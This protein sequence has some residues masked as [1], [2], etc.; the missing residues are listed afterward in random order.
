MTSDS[1]IHVS[2]IVK[3]CKITFMRSEKRKKKLLHCVERF[4]FNTRKRL[5]RHAIPERF[6]YIGIQSPNGSQVIIMKK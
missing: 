2:F 5:C 1:R 6:G 3:T 4:Y